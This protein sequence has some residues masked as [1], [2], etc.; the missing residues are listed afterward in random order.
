MDWLKVLE[1]DYGIRPA[2]KKDECFYCQRKVGEPHG[3]E[4]VVVV[5]KIAIEFT[6]DLQERGKWT[7]L[8]CLERPYF[9]KEERC[10]F[11]ANDGT[12]CTDNLLGMWDESCLSIYEPNALD[13]KAELEKYPEAHN[14]ACICHISTAKTLPIANTLPLRA[15]H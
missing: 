6:F 10:D 9:W 15:H 14:T 7:A 12:W 5:R 8:F 4:C 11:W 1:N 13:L 2:G 3:G